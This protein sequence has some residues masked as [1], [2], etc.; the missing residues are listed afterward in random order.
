M[1]LSNKA[2]LVS[3]NI[4]QW[5]GR[6]LDRKATGTVESSHATQGNVGNYHKRLLPGAIEL[7]KVSAS[8]AMLRVFFYTQTLPW[9]ADGTRILSAVNYLDFTRDFKTHQNHYENS[10]KAFMTAY[11]AL[12]IDAQSKLGELFND[13]E[14]PSEFSLAKKFACGISFMPMPDVNDFRVELSDSERAEFES[15]MR[16]TESNA[17]QDCWQRIYNVVSKA[18]SKLSEVKPIFHDSLIDNMRDLCSLLPKLNITDNADLERM[19]T[20]LELTI[21][22]IGNPDALRASSLNRSKACNQLK[23]IESR[24]GAFMGVQS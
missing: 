7:S 4:S 19:R 9:L 20:E 6:K 1:S 15:K 18:T 24:M 23:D 5:T 21:A 2:L 10:V 14:Y 16:E 12:R 13:A 22:S 8:A 17:L 11:P 3:L